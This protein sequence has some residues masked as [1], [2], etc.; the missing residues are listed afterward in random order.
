MVFF[1]CGLFS[2]TAV[3]AKWKLLRETHGVQPQLLMENCAC[4][5]LHTTV[6]L[7]W[8][9]LMGTSLWIRWKLLHKSF[10]AMQIQVAKNVLLYQS[11]HQ[12]EWMPEFGVQR[13]YLQ[14]MLHCHAGLTGAQF[15]PPRAKAGRGWGDHL[16]PLRGI[17]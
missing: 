6:L 14:Q 15:Y 9:R 7:L 17:R 11:F 4:S 1:C 12:P 13:T 2:S 3:L 5:S 16:W 8:I 10:H